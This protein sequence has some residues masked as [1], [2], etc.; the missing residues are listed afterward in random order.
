MLQYGRLEM[1]SR[2]NKWTNT[3]PTEMEGLP[4][5]AFVDGIRAY[6]QYYQILDEQSECLYDVISVKIFSSSTAV[7]NCVLGLQYLL[8]FLCL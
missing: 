7:C 5:F 3:D 8:V 1:Q 2:L 4:R 6:V